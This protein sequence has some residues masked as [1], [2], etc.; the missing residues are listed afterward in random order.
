MIRYNDWK[1]K[2][3]NE[4]K[5]SQRQVVFIT[6]LELDIIVDLIFLYQI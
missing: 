6:S 4:I 3:V 2:S 5:P 1:E